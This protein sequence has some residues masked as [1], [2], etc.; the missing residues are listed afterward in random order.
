MKPNHIGIGAGPAGPV[1][2]GPLF[3]QFNEIHYRKIV[4]VLRTRLLLPIGQ[5]TSK[6]LPMPLNQV[7]HR[8]CRVLQPISHKLTS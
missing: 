4:C 1:L 6:V 7:Y 8:N 5:T 2:A 3:W